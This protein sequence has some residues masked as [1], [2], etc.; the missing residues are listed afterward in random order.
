MGDA[1]AGAP[2]SRPCW[3][4]GQYPEAVVAQL[5]FVRFENVE[6]GKVGSYVARGCVGDEL[7][8]V[9]PQLL[10]VGHLPGDKKHGNIGYSAAV[11]QVEGRQ[12]HP[13]RPRKYH[14]NDIVDDGDQIA[15]V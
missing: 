3:F 5:S 14:K 9:E 15:Q 12:K 7:L 13:L 6:F 10:Q 2:E 4:A 11:A 8:A 1:T